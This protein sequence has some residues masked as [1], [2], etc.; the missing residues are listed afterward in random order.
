MDFRK[1]KDLLGE[2]QIPNF[3]YWGIHTQRAK[4]NFPVSGRKVNF[5][6]VKG[7][8]LVKKACI[9]ANSQLG[10]IPEDKSKAIIEACDDIINGKLDDQ[11][12]LDYLQGG[13]GTSINMNL[14]EVLANRALEILQKPKGDY[15]SINPIED[16]NLH[17]STNDT[18]PTAVKISVIFALKE[19]S[20]E[21][22]FLQSA[23]QD[24]EK[25]YAQI[26]KIGRTEL[27]E[28][29]PMT[30]GVEFSG[31]AEAV[32]RDRWRVFKCE[33]RLSQVNLGS[34]A[35]GTGLGAQRNY[36]FLVIE[37]LRE[38]TNLGLSRTENL[39][40]ATANADFF[41]EVS[42]IL[43]AHASNIA[44]IANDL[45]LLNFINEIKLEQVQSGSS[46]M[47]GKVNPVIMEALIQIGMKV[48][49]L[50]FLITETASRSSLQM[51]EFMPLLA[52][53]IL[54]A[55]ELLIS[56]NKIFSKA[57]KCLQANKEICYENFLKSPSLITAFIPY[58]GYDQA[59]LYIKEFF[60]QNTGKNI[61]SFLEEKL[62][63][64]LVGKILR[65]ENLTSLGYKKDGKD[66]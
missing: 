54:E 16:V 12:A 15:S 14:N 60:T 5:R 51:V 6:I 23:F 39:V 11:F 50:D 45:R 43:K 55:I 46:I 30:L 10:F 32:A 26:L 41:V 66:S 37:K 31:F 33:E 56:A 19:L 9:L 3:A 63:K 36:I 22:S 48:F 17:Q 57:V 24:K 28:A 40:G 20:Q 35:I 25:E 59:V 47:P 61:R 42:G 49:S 1:E 21:I 4:E 7:L 27:Q 2:K 53:S 29:V 13:A 38:I 18:Y 62:G 44:K 65:P 58:I 64:E 8:A 34:T 52:E